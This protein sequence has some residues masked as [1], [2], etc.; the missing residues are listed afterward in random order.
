MEIFCFHN[1]TELLRDAV[2]YSENFNEYS[3]DT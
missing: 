2:K 3:N 1:S